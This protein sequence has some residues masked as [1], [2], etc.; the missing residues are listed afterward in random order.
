MKTHTSHGKDSWPNGAQLVISISMQ[1]ESGGQSESAAS[2]FIPPLTKYRDFP[3]HTWFDYGYKEGMWRLLDLWDKHEI[4][5]TS[6][7]VGQSAE[8]NP[9]IARAVSDR[10]HEIASHGIAWDDQFDMTYEEEKD[11][12]K[13]GIDVLKKIT[14]QQPIGHNCNWLRRS[15]NTLKVLQELGVRYHIDDVSRDEPFVVMVKGKKFGVV[16][17]TIRCN[18]IVLIEV[19]NFSTE[20]F[21]A[22]L[23]ME[24]DQLYLEG[25]T[26]RRQMSVS[27]HDRISGAPAVITVLDQFIQYAKGHEN[28]VFMRKDEI[29][30]VVLEESDPIVDGEEDK[31]NS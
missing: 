29:A 3:A 28:V 7:I 8:K 5:V 17:Y 6:H 9:E 27:A 15:E 14:G 25:K 18:D 4:K 31:F 16:P 21:L 19:R 11:F 1:F 22:Q 13:R 23:K 30:T 12:I 20:Q 2:P 26:H 10:G 24:F